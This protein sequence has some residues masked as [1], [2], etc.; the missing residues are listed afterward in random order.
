MKYM[1]S[2]FFLIRV[3]DENDPDL[4]KPDEDSE[5]KTTNSTESEKKRIME[6]VILKPE[7]N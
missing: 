6:K 4:K 5:N 3:V 2:K 1:L 7:D